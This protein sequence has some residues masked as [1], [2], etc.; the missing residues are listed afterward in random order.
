[1][2]AI[3]VGAAA[4]RKAVCSLGS[5]GR[6]HASA[7]GSAGAGASAS[8]GTP[9]REALTHTD[10]LFAIGASAIAV[11][12]A[13]S[14][15]RRRLEYQT[16]EEEMAI[17]LSTTRRMAERHRAIILQR[18][19]ELAAASGLPAAKAAAFEAKLKVLDQELAVEIHKLVEVHN[20][21]PDIDGT[22]PAADRA[23]PAGKVA[24][25]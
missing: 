15:V 10:R 8:P 4:S 1:M 12:M 25:W 19:P 23:R 18:V 2:H 13:I 21:G 11:S 17:E 14:M 24:V 5:A 3:R 20:Q 22:G 7:A 6:R 16:R 9:L